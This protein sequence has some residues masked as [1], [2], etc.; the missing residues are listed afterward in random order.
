[1]ALST[2]NSELLA[3]RPDWIWVLAGALLMLLA[4]VGITEAALSEKGFSPTVNDTEALWLNERE[5]ASSLGQGALILVGASRI[6]LDLDLR[7]LREKTG[8]EPVQLAIDG[9]SYVPVLQGLA[10]DPTIRGTVVVDLMPGPVS[11]EVGPTGTSQHYQSEYDTF[12]AGNVRWPTYRTLDAWLARVIRPHLINFADGGRPWDSLVNR[13]TN[14]NASPQYL[15]SFA[16]R[17]RQADYQRVTMPDF[18]LRRVYRHIGSP[19][20]IDINQSTDHLARQLTEYI[21]R[22]HPMPESEQ[23]QKGLLDLEDA[24]AAIQLHGGTVIIM[25]MPTSG[26]VQEADSRRFPRALYWDRVA[27]NTTARTIHWQDHPGLAGFVCPDG[28]HLDK[29][30]TV[31]FSNAFVIVAGLGRP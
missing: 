17:S 18:Y 27:A 29:R 19:V 3:H 5:R 2:S 21:G 4:Y 9:S 16:D 1:M 24:V 8:L 28:S 15:S 13:V 20:E 25:T 6:Q 23:T 12:S 7:V 11:F 31:A 26:L 30:D 10:R 14:A 22:L